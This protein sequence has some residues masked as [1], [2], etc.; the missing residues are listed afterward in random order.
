MVIVFLQSGRTLTHWAAAGG[1]A[2]ILKLLINNYS[3][4]PDVK[5]EACHLT[6][7]SASCYHTLIIC[8]EKLLDILAFGSLCGRL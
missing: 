2:D 4:D 1:H 7:S 5:D 8:G 6:F 3:V